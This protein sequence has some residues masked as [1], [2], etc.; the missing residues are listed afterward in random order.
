MNIVLYWPETVHVK[1]N[2]KVLRVTPA[3]QEP[4]GQGSITPPVGYLNPALA[5]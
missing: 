3:L 2:G 5:D 1:G 4:H